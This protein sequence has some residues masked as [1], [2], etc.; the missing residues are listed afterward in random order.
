MMF[1]SEDLKL[2]P[3]KVQ[4]GVK[5]WLAKKFSE[6]LKKVYCSMKE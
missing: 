3:R 6:N 2:N 1:F 4:N 5:T